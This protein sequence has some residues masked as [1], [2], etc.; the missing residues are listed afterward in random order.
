M[1]RF[2]A[3]SGVRF[4]IVQAPM[5]WIA[6][7]TLAGAVSRAGGLGV[8][9]TSSGDTAGCQ[10]EISAMLEA[11][12]PFGVNLPLRFLKDDAMLLQGVAEVAHSDADLGLLCHI[13]PIRISA[14]PVGIVA[15]FIV[16]VGQQI[17]VFADRPQR[18]VMKA[19]HKG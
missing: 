15:V 2:L 12:L 6:R 13:D 18:P 17:L 5:G 8:I 16:R 14:D 19:V 9:E 3:H 1:N 11:G 10:A 7:R 4:P